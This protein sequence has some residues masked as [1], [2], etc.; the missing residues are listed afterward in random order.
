PDQSGIE[1]I[2]ALKA[3]RPELEVMAYTVFEDRETVFAALKAGATSYV[4]KGSTPRELIEA[5]HS[6]NQGGAP[7]SPKIA[8]AVIQEFQARPAA[9]PELLSRRETEVLSFVEQGLSYKEIAS[10]L[11][12]SPHTVHSHIK[13]IYEKL[14]ANGKHDALE[15]ARRKGLI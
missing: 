8:R 3:Q 13:K 15:K 1:L 7:M 14:Q 4:L 10:N 5:L 2:A 6:L 9:S 11:N 12:L